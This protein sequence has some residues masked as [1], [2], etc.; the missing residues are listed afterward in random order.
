MDIKK[1]AEELENDIIEQ[2]RYLHSHPEL[3]FQETE[4]TKYLVSQIEKIGL[5]ANTYPDYN[6][7]WT[8]ITGSHAKEGDKVVLLRADIDALP[9]KEDTGLAFS[10]ENPG[11]MHACGHDNHMA[12]LLGAMQILNTHK[13]ELSGTV[14]ILFQAAEESCH[15][16]EYYVNKGLLDDV[17]ACFGVHV[18]GTL[19]APYINIDDGARMSSC[20]N[21]TIEVE[22]TSAHGSAPNYGIDAITTAAAII[23]QIQTLVSRRNDPRDPLA[24]TIGEITGGQ[25]FNIIADKVVMKGTVRAHS[26]EVRNK[27]EGWLRKLVEN[28]ANANDAKASLIYE[29]YPGVLWNDSGLAE[30]ARNSVTKLYGKEGLGEHPAIMGSEDFSYFLDKAPG[31]YALI[32]IRN[33]SKGITYQNHNPHFDVDESVLKRGA[34]LYAQFAVDYLEKKQKNG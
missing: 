2:R 7:V 16:A 30:I 17:D 5:K 10:S 18:W 33:E 21:F 29:Y 3:S 23:M 32:G 34:A 25:R 12:M 24:I 9:V 4:T 13:D 15:G 27:I 14:R 11:V 31:A 8:D 6:G 22:G 28:V 20:D 19:D 26:V 1:E